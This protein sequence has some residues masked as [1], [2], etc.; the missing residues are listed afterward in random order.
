MSVLV[1]KQRVVI[2]EGRIV[3][4]FFFAILVPFKLLVLS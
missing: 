3:Q 2:V 1:L 4:E